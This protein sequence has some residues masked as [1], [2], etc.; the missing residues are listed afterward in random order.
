MLEE[1]F[2]WC[3]LMQPVRRHRRRWSKRCR[4]PARVIVWTSMP[5]WTSSRRLVEPY[6]GCSLDTGRTSTMAPVRGD[7]PHPRG[8]VDQEGT[9]LRQWNAQRLHHVPERH[10]AVTQP[11][12]CSLAQR[13][14]TRSVA[15]ALQS[16]SSEAQDHFWTHRLS[17]DPAGWLT[18]LL[19]QARARQ[20]PNKP[21]SA[22]V[23]SS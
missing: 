3:C 12:M 1:W 23:V 6:I 9:D 19:Q 13:H 22:A 4:R 7:G 16:R 5:K 8:S 21:H 2:E 14:G 11:S 17:A 15:W 18:D 20:R 10:L